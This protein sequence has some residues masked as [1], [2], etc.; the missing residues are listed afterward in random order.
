MERLKPFRS[1]GFSL[2]L[3]VAVA[4]ATGIGCGGGALL[5]LLLMRFVVCR[6]WTHC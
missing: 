5:T 6:E 1:K 2:S 4:V 3:L